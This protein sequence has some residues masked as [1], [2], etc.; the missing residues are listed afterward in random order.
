MGDPTYRMTAL[1]GG[2]IEPVVVV[3]R[4]VSAG[5]SPVI[6]SLGRCAISP[7]RIEPLPP[8]SSLRSTMAVLGSLNALPSALNSRILSRPG[9]VGD[10]QP[11]EGRSYA[12]TQEVP[13][14]GP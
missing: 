7:P 2:P 5:Y 1:M 12:S 6:R 14:R 11:C 13:G 4:R 10:S 3:G 8:V 9:F